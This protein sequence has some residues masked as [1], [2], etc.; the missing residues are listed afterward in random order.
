[1]SSTSTKPASLLASEGAEECPAA[2]LM[3]LLCL[4][5]FMLGSSPLFTTLAYYMQTDVNFDVAWLGTA[6]S[7]RTFFFC[8]GS[9]LWGSMA[10]RGTLTRKQILVIGALFAGLT[11]AVTWMFVTNF[12]VLIL[13]RGMDGLFV[14]SMAPV[15]YSIV[16]DRFDDARR[17]L[18]FGLLLT[19]AQAGNWITQALANVVAPEVFGTTFY[20]W[21]LMLLVVGVLTIILAVLT[22]SILVVPEVK[23]SASGSSQETVCRILKRSSYR[24]LVL[25]GVFGI[26]P[27]VSMDF[28]Q[29]FFSY[30]NLNAGQTSVIFRFAS[31]VAISSALLGGLVGDQLNAS[32]P[33]HGRVLAAQISIFVG[34]PLAFLTLMISPIGDPFIFYTIMTTILYLVTGWVVSATNN[35]I[36]CALAGEDHERSLIFGFTNVVSTFVGTVGRAIASFMFAFVL[37]AL[38][39]DNACNDPSTAPPGCSGNSSAVGRSLFIMCCIGWVGAGLLYS[40]LYRTY[41]NDVAAIQ[42]ERNGP[43]DAGNELVGAS[44]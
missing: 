4:Y 17:G 19:S 14:S 41:P 39:Y 7:S 5:S 18:C 31:F 23:V 21:K 1:M 9:L 32:R 24:V 26:M 36:L 12:V 33:L 6:G 25:Q 30:S 11:T 13:L 28:W 37:N 42:E 20:G 40:L 29:F 10:S 15:A 38:G 8:I 3:V 43:G 27:W 16:G 2:P 22:Q 44:S 35:P 34:V